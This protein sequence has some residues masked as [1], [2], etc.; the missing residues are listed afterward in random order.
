[1]VFH[2]VVELKTHS[3]VSLYGVYSL[4]RS[5]GNVCMVH[6]VWMAELK[7]RIFIIDIG[8]WRELPKGMTN[9]IWIRCDHL[10]S[11]IGVMAIHFGTVW[12]VRPSRDRVLILPRALKPRLCVDF[13][14]YSLEFGSYFKN[15]H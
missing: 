15:L 14:R 3:L 11:I 9:S 10:K 1:M 12:F 5:V 13:A 8:V 4:R 6:S 2:S 7:F